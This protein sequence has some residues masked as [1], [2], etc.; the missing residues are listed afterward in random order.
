MIRK[1]LAIIVVI[2][3]YI[4]SWYVNY[5]HANIG[6]VNY[7]YLPFPVQMT[8]CGSSYDK[9]STCAYPYIWWGIVASVVFWIIVLGIS[10]IIVK[11]KKVNNMV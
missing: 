1:T 8:S 6:G 2:A 3:A 4:V 11:K 9:Y 5:S 7:R 10:Y